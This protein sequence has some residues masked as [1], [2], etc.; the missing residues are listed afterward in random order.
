MDREVERPGG[1]VAEDEASDHERALLCARC[2]NAITDLDAKIEM[3]GAHEHVFCNPHGH[4]FRIG[5]FAEAPGAASSGA[6]EAFFSWF[7]GYDWRV[8]VCRRCLAHLG[9]SFGNEAFW[10]LVLDALV[11]GDERSLP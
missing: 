3:S 11:I 4:V 5:C 8:A 7:P 6:A 2:R 10:G 1:S 9:W